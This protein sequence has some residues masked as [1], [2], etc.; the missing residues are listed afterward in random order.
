MKLPTLK[1]KE[2]QIGNS[3][4]GSIW[5]LAAAG[6]AQA[7]GIEVTHVPF[8]G[9]APAITSLLGNHIDAVTVSYAEVQ[10]Q[11]EAGKLRSLAVLAPERLAD[12]PDV[13]T[14]SELGYG[15]LSI[16]AWRGYAVPE[17]TDP[18]VVE[19]IKNS[20]LKATKSESFVTFMANT[21]N[22]IDILVDDDFAD[23]LDYEWN[24]FGTLMDSLGL[25]K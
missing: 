21:H 22:A 2:L 18:A 14:M 3:G 16:A 20:F 9:A 6:F 19:Y 5:H 17:G 1:T 25:S 23:R 12:C 7:A 10:S 15:D 11:V 4:I 24:Y 13:P 8:D